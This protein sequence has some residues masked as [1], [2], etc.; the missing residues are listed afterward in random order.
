LTLFI[1]TTNSVRPPCRRHCRRRSWPCSPRHRCRG[2]G[3]WSSRTLCRPAATASGACCCRLAGTVRASPLLRLSRRDHAR[4]AWPPTMVGRRV[5][6][7]PPCA[8]HFR[9]PTKAPTWV[10]AS[11][12]ASY[13]R[14]V[15]VRARTHPPAHARTHARMLARAHARMHTGEMHGK[16]HGCKAC[17]ARRMRGQTR[18]GRTRASESERERARARAM[19]R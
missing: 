15:C 12:Q 13:E 14:K 7:N 17:Q 5:R 9:R 16:C 1:I 10:S 11:G 18:K 6:S 19:C 3:P 2:P 4:G 8:C